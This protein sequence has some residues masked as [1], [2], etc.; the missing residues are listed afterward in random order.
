MMSSDRNLFDQTS[1]AKLTSS[2][3]GKG[4]HDIPHVEE[5]PSI[6][7]TSPDLEGVKEKSPHRLDQAAEFLRDH[8]FSHDQ[9]LQLL[10][11]EAATGKLL[12]KIDY[13]LLPLLCGTYMLQF[14]DKQALTYA[15]VFDLLS[16]THMSSAQ[17]ALLGTWF[18]LGM[19][20][21]DALRGQH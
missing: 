3:S 9:V 16:D 21:T 11:D 19:L 20:V 8:D 15:A 10:A 13:T 7:A 5:G 6:R 12:R 4:P 2:Q 18:Y 17:Y 1:S 14:I